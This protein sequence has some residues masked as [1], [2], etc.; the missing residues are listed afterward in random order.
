MN[1]SKRF[2]LAAGFLALFLVASGSANAA[3]TFQVYIPGAVGTDVG[4]DED[5]WVTNSSSFTLRIVGC[6]KTSGANATTS[7]DNLHLVLSVPE[8][9]TGSVSITGGGGV[10]LY[11]TGADENL[12]TDVAGLDGFDIRQGPLPAI[13]GLNDHYPFKDD[14]SDFLVYSIADDFSNIGS[15]HDYNAETNTITANAG[16][17]EEMDLQ[18]SISGFTS[19]HFD[20]YGLETT[21]KG[22]T[23]QMNASSH[24]ATYYIP[25][26]GALLLA[27]LGLTGIGALRR[28]QIIA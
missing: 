24:D 21:A 13:Q 5:S 28:R 11:T 14:V 18:V 1:R 16:V 10:S 20:M 4:L 17:G 26:P 3:Q 25:A 27:A 19:V 2:Y 12:L 8:G 9:Q 6:F 15:I 23:W 7:L 22:S